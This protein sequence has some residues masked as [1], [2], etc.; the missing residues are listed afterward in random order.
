MLALS[1]VSPPRLQIMI[2]DSGLV[3]VESAAGRRRP[4]GADKAGVKTPCWGGTIVK[5]WEPIALMLGWEV[6][7]V[8][9]AHRSGGRHSCTLMN[10]YTRRHE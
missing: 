8:G 10:K 3:A 5:T 4:S 1:A 9:V 6:P 7:A 2:A